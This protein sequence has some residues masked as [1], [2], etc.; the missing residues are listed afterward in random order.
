M[1][2]TT[3]TTPLAALALRRRTM[4]TPIGPLELVAGPA[5]PA[6]RP[7]ARRGRIPGGAGRCGAV[8]AGRGQGPGGWPGGRGGD[9]GGSGR[10]PGGGAPGRR[11]G[12]ARGVLRRDPPG[13]RPRP[14]PGRDG[15]PAPGVEW[16]A[17]HPLRADHQ[18]R[19]AGR[20]A[21]RRRGPPAPSVPPTGAT[22][23]RSSS[24]ATEW[25]PRP[26]RSPGS[27]AGSDIEGL[28]ARPRT[29][30]P[31]RRG[32]GGNLAPVPV[33]W[34][35]CR[36][37]RPD[38][39]PRGRS[40]ASRAHRL[41]GFNRNG[42]EVGSDVGRSLGRLPPERAR[43]CPSATAPLPLAPL[44]R[45]VGHAPRPPRHR[46]G[47]ARSCRCSQLLP[48]RGPAARCAPTST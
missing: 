32:D 26:V 6:R 44:S 41:R 43:G 1:T 22:R 29:G 34:D 24:R 37:D 33:E 48:G 9:R 15:L 46:A 17:R 14:R 36:I 27:P 39:H 28:A 30:R 45:R 5:G 7:L 38:R 16:P 3:P 18:L 12:P 42:R 2:S 31:R 40:G 25:W 23:C 13:V 4:S 10:A 19:R 8:D 47:Y 21:R 11:R 35:R 20:R